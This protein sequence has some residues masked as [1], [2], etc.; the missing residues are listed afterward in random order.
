MQ[1]GLGLDL[2]KNAGRDNQAVKRLNGPGGRLKNIDHALM[3]AHLKL[4][5]ALLVDVRATKHRIPLNSRGNR[6]G[7]ADAGIGALGVI[8]DFFRRR[9]QRP[10]I[11]RFHPDSNSR[12][13]CHLL[14]FKN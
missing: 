11:V 6:N 3:R 13:L 9:I 14:R 4:L 10:M 2:H 1:K 12:L 8:D 5:A 7:A